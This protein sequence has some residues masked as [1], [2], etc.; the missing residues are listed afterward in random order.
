MHAQHPL[1]QNNAY[2]IEEV[3]M[4]TS[5]LGYGFA[6]MLGAL[7][8]GVNQAVMAADATEPVTATATIDWSRLQLSVTGVNGSSPTVQYENQH[9]SLDSNAWTNA[10]SETN[11][12]NISN[13]TSTAQTTADAGT[14]YA[15]A[16]ASTLD[17]SGVAVSGESGNANSSGNRSLDFSFDGPGVLTVTVPYTLTLTGDT[18][19]CYYCYGDYASVSAYADF[20]SYTDNGSADSHS[21]AS[22]SLYNDYWHSSPESQSGTLVFGIFASGAGTGSLA[23]NFDLSTQS[24]SPIPEPESY[25]MLLAGLGLMGMMVRR[26]KMYKGV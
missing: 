14:T 26:R 13:W 11:S 21:N 7:S 23:F 8:A 20:Y 19:N 25:A 4:H 3:N 17:F 15:N 5:K 24:I 6:F 1:N 10:A 12:K 2:L 18:R 22:F 9:T 16:V